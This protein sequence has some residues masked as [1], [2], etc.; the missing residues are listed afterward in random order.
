MAKT[1]PKPVVVVSRCLTC[2][3]CRYDGELLSNEF[4]D[5]LEPHVQLKAVCPEMEIGLGCPRERVI[6]VKS[7]DSTRLFQPATRR[8]LTLRMV[9]FAHKYLNKLRSVDGFL[10]KSKSP[11]CAISDAKLFNEPLVEKPIGKGAGLFART[12]LKDFGH[13][14]VEDEERMEDPRVRDRWV[15][16][17]FA[18]TAFR[19]ANRTRSLRALKKFHAET[20]T[21]ID[22]CSAPATRRMDKLLENIDKRPAP[23]VVND[24][25][26]EYYKALTRIKKDIPSF[27]GMPHIRGMTQAQPR[28]SAARATPAR[29]TA[30]TGKSKAP[31]KKTVK[32][33][34]KKTILKKKAAK[35]KAT[36]K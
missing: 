36:R 28:K 26:A 3:K 9:H 6:V 22:A 19:T 15:T 34:A 16:R 35:K 27:P 21:F 8:D 2:K 18:V 29:K 32:K 14:P 11:S 30:A 13:L 5:R 24:Y 33:A 10:L 20:A 31:A 23:D 7:G 12:V 1:S 4:I 17:V 25:E